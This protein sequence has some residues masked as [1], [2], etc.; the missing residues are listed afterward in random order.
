MSH[1]QFEALVKRNQGMS[2][3]DLLKL[4]ETK[5]EHVS[6]RGSLSVELSDAVRFFATLW[7]SIFAVCIPT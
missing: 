6:P 4:F 5:D 2:F 1:L 7:N 3:Q